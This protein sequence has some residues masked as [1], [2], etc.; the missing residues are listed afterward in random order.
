M[1]PGSP[2]MTASPER[3]IIEP[4]SIGFPPISPWLIARGD[5]SGR[6]EGVPR[7]V[8]AGAARPV[9]RVINLLY[10]IARPLAEIFFP[11]W[12]YDYVYALGKY[13]SMVALQKVSE[14]T[15]NWKWFRSF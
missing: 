7:K 9:T 4:D 10:R 12:L 14:D 1:T 15:R 5:V 6:C 11:R 13:P 2:R 3:Q 8:V